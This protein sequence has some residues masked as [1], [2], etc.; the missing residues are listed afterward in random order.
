[1]PKQVAIEAQRQLRDLRILTAKLLAARNNRSIVL[2]EMELAQARKIVGNVFW[3]ND[4][5]KPMM[6][7]MNEVFGNEHTA[8]LARQTKAKLGQHVEIFPFHY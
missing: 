7:Q 4:R 1:M 2:S 8:K 6:P 3:L 5:N